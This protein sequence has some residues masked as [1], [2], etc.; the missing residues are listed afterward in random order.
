[1][2]DRQPPEP[3]I[4]E[5]ARQAADHVP[6]ETVAG[7]LQRQRRVGPLGMPRRG[8]HRPN[9]RVHD[10]TASLESSEIV[11][12]G[13]TRRRLRED[14]D[15]EVRRHVPRIEPE[16]RRDRRSVPDALLVG[17][18]RGAEPRVKVVG[19]GLDAG[20]TDGRRKIRVE[21]TSERQVIDR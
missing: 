17:L 15:I 4:D 20:D 5:R 12:A 21:R 10:R 2:I 3:D 8:G 7:D 6:K 18:R 16:E 9:R 13:K 1:M 19:D 14:L 11:R